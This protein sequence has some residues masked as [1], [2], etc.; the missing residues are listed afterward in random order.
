M[1]SKVHVNNKKVLLSLIVIASNMNPLGK[2]G[3]KIRYLRSEEQ[4]YVVNNIQPEGVDISNLTESIANFKPNPLTSDFI[5]GLFDGDGNLT[6]SIAS[7]KQ[8]E[9][10]KFFKL[11]VKFTFSIVQDVHSLSLL[12]EIKSYFNNVGEIYELSSKCSIY[13]VGSKFD[14]ISV[15]FPKMTNKEYIDKV[16][17]EN[18]PFIKYNQIYCIW[19][20]IDIL[21]RNK[22][23]DEKLLNEVMELAYYTRKDSD[24][25]S[26]KQYVQGIKN[27][28]L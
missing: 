17:Y 9:T 7:L 19:K 6:L 18:L 13:K 1:F 15:I 25:V 14:L 27:K 3:N 23:L 4:K 21:S 10:E 12:N 8:L 20:I 16:K 24:I 5:N 28:W 22:T 2:L 26:L 11:S